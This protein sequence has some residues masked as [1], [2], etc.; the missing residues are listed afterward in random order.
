MQTR[1]YEQPGKAFARMYEVPADSAA[2]YLFTARMLLRQ[3]F[4]PVAEEYAQKAV[5]LDPKLPRA[6]FLLGRVAHV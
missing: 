5:T 4:E 1:D 6:H 3:E 2:S